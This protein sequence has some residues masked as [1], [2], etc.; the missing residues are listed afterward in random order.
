[1]TPTQWLITFLIVSC[2]VLL[3]IVILLATKTINPCPDV[4]TT[5][6]TASLTAKTE[7]TLSTDNHQPKTEEPSLELKVVEEHVTPEYLR[8]RHERI[9][10][11]PANQDIPRVK[12]A[13]QIGVDSEGREYVY[14]HNGLKVL[15]GK[16]AYHGEFA[17]ILTTNRG[18]HEPQEE[19]VFQEV[20]GAIQHESPVMIELGSYWAFYSLWFKHV[21]HGEVYL[22]EPMKHALDIGKDNLEFNG[23]T[24]HYY[25]GYIDTPGLLEEHTSTWGSKIRID[26]F[27]Q[28][29]KIDQLTILHSDIQGAELDMLKS[30]EQSLKSRKIDYVFISTHTNELHTECSNELLAHGYVIIASA[31]MDESFCWDGILVAKRPGLALPEFIPLQLRS[32]TFDVPSVL[33]AQ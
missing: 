20:L 14:I 33:S 28:D 31:N 4:L 19:K 23:M 9:I 11:D 8:L 3:V 22:C 17:D 1:M 10:F 25:Q 18:C 5:P 12:E 6:N 7:H 21:T 16:H 13:G 32:N 2:I 24:G 26:Q 30:A 27:L 15:M 29:H